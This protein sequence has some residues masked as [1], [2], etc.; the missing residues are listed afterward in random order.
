MLDQLNT[1]D[2]DFDVACRWLQANEDKWT[3]WVPEQGKCFTQFGMYNAT[4]MCWRVR[5]ESIGQGT[6]VKHNEILITGRENMKSGNLG[7][8][9]QI[10]LKR[11]CGLGFWDGA[12]MCKTENNICVA[13]LKCC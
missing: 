3:T 5:Q 12:N 10:P 6:M 4:W 8:V 2:G 11:G 1:D 7:T 9:A 13:T